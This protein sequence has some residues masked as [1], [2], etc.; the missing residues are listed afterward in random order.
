MSALQREDFATALQNL[1]PLVEEGHAG[2]A[3][4]F[5]ILC[6]TVFVL[7]YRRINGPMRALSGNITRSEA[8][9][10][11]FRA[12]VKGK[13]EFAD[14]A[15]T[16]NQMLDQQGQ[17]MDKLAG[18]LETTPA[19]INSMPAHITLLDDEGRIL[20]VN[21][22]WRHFGIDNGYRDEALGIGA[23]LSGYLHLHH[24]RLC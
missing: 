15:C 16:F 5:G 4:L 1:E 6:V 23:Q 21:D 9:E 3:A 24:G 13:D 17:M 14:L 20:D 18:A 11:C 7:L 22:P 8:G 2:A 19:L 12:L 10:S